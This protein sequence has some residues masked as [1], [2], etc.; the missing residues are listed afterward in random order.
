[1]PYIKQEQRENLDPKI[2]ELA[3]AIEKEANFT[4]I[5]YLGLINYSFTKVLLETFG[6]PKYSKIAMIT[7]VLENIKQE[8]Y[9]R[10]AADYEDIKCEENGDLF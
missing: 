2:K 1:M 4:P 7:G 9:R 10:Y 5:N 8:F 3:D 6:T